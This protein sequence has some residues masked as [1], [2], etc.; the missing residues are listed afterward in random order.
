MAISG[1]QVNPFTARKTH[2]LVKLEI[3]LADYFSPTALFQF[4]LLIAAKLFLA[5]LTNMFSTSILLDHDGKT[6][7]LT[8]LIVQH[9]YV[10]G[11]MWMFCYLKN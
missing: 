2:Q 10:R 9:F 3:I 5:V 11:N 1:C 4:Q 8:L 6:S 7:E